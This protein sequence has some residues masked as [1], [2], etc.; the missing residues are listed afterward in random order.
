[1]KLSW[2][3]VM[4]ITFGLFFCFMGYFVVKINSDPQ[5]KY[6]LVTPNYYQEELK[7]N[8][9][10][11]ALKNAVKWADNLSHKKEKEH[12]LLYPLPMDR[13]FRVSGYR[14]SDPE[15]DFLVSSK[16]EIDVNTIRLRLG[17]LDKGVWKLTIQW[18]EKG[19]EFRIHYK[20]NID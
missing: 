7:E 10:N 3:R 12:L 20:L 18:E 8:Q 15:K 4:L 6:H 5:L 1:M 11:A 14:P 17:L 9:K 19:E 16:S 2:A 13:W